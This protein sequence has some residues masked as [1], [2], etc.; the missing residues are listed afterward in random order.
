M[1]GDPKFGPAN[2]PASRGSDEFVAWID[3]MGIESAM[4]VYPNVAEV[5][6]GKLHLAVAEHEADASLELYPMTDG[7]YWRV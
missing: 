2:I 3:I 4:A 6:I 5:N 1:R 7:I